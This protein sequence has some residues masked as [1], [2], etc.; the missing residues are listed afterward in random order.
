VPDPVSES[1]HRGI[2]TETCDSYNTI[3][4]VVMVLKHVH[5]SYK[6]PPSKG[7]NVPPLECALDLRPN[8]QLLRLVHKKTLC[9]YHVLSWIIP[10]GEVLWFEYEM[11]SKVSCSDILI[12][13]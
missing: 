4:M 12:T 10:C 5:K 3:Q 2:H 7:M 6:A 9:F 8:F 13:S 11:S 1:C